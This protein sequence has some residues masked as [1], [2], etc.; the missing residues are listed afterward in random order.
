MNRRLLGSVL[1][2]LASVVFLGVSATSAAG[3]DGAD[4]ALTKTAD[5]KSV[6]IGENVTYTITLTNHGPAPAT[7]VQFGDSVPD[8][9][10]L[11]SF[12]C[13]RGTIVPQSFCAV[14]RVDVGETVTATLVATPIENTARSERRFTNTA[15]ISASATTDPVSDNNT[16]S[17]GMTIRKRHL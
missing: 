7:D 3:Q 9:L 5:R 12:A 10:N 14:D 8:P 6:R 4:L 17:V 13:S 2:L 11:V 1:A 15:F 16:A